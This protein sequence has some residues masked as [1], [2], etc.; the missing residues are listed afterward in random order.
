MT[1][2]AK[3]PTSNIPPCPKCK[4]PGKLIELKVP[5]K[6]EESFGLFE[7]TNEECKAV[8]YLSSDVEHYLEK[9]YRSE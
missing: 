7:C 1:Q 5:E 4:V 2:D 9:I 6:K 8:S 3:T